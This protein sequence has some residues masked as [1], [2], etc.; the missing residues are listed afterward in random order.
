MRERE[1][2]HLF[3]NRELSQPDLFPSFLRPEAF[4]L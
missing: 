3:D 4:L 2:A 1:E